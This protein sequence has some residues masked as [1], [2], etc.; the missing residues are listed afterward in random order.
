MTDLLIA[1][2]TGQ[3]LG[4]AAGATFVGLLFSLM[5]PIFSLI[6]LRTAII[7]GLTATLVTGIVMGWLLANGEAYNYA[8]EQLRTEGKDIRKLDQF[9]KNFVDGYVDGMAKILRWY[10][11]WS[12]IPLMLPVSVALSATGWSMR[13]LIRG[14]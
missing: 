3:M 13:R 7:A 14:R 1:Q 9:D 2:L 11:W 10:N 5:C 4:K 12:L 6:K 8:S